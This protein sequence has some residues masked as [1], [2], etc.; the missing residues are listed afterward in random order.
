MYLEANGVDGG[1]VYLSVNQGWNV[2]PISGDV[3]VPKVP[4]Q[5]DTCITLN[6]NECAVV[7]PIEDYSA[8]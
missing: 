1:V 5:S 2:R 7:A 8:G 3:G 4:I 6:T